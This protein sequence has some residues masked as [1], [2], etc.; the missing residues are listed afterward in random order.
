MWHAGFP[1]GLSWD[2]APGDSWLADLRGTR[3]A[4]AR[5]GFPALLTFATFCRVLGGTWL[6]PKPKKARIP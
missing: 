6:G 1:E 4:F 3:V 5:A 2:L